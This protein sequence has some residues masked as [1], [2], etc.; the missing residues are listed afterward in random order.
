M[1]ELRETAY[2][3]V[4]LALHVRGRLPDGRHRIETIFAFCEDGD[5]LLFELDDA[6]GL[7]ID[8]VSPTEIE[9]DNLIL[10]AAYALRSATATRQGA[11]IRLTKR[12]PI[13]AGLGGGSADAAAALRALVRLWRIDPE[14]AGAVAPK[15][16]ADVPAC[17]VSRT[18][19]GTG[20]GDEIAI[21]LEPNL[22]GTPILLVN[23]AVPLATG[24]VFG[25]WD[26]VDRGPLGDDWKSARNDL[27]PA[28]IHMVPAI[29]DVLG[30]LRQQPGAEFVRMSGSGATCF[31]LFADDA[32]RD[33]AA[34]IVP[35]AWWHLA[36]SLR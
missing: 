4:N 28:A 33:A 9:G 31:A 34:A 26:G 6:L 20:A 14:F 18:C 12:L 1:S 2:A 19:R 13:A 5:E 32:S 3:K 30:W 22:K 17:L 7:I 10:R 25:G 8:G 15:L 21:L 35:E 24:E 16:G 11:Q 27:E 23:P 29:A 36:T